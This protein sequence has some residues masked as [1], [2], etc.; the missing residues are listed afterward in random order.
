M[1]DLALALTGFSQWNLV[2]TEGRSQELSHRPATSEVT[3][4]EKTRLRSDIS[5][6]QKR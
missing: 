5:S 6:L 1:T 4:T 2:A 3:A